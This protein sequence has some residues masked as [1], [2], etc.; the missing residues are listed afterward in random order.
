MNADYDFLIAGGGH[1]GLACGAVLARAGFSVCVVERNESIGGGCV[2][3]EVTLPGFQHDLYGSSHVWIHANPAFQ[4]LRQE[5]AQFGLDYIWEEDHITGHPDLNGPGI[6]IYRDV[7]KT[8]E[9]IAVYSREDAARYREIYDDWQLIR[10]GFIRT[11]FSP[12]NPPS[13]APAAFEGSVEGLN[14]MREFN[15]SSRAFVLEKFENDF[16]RASILGWAL[17]PQIF[18]DTECAGQSF[19]VLIPGIHTYGNAIPRGGSQMMPNAFARLIEARGGHVMTGSPIAQFIVREGECKGFRLADGSE[20]LAG[21]AVV[22]GLGPKVSFLDC[23]KSEDLP[24]DFVDACRRFSYGR[25]SIC[26]VHYALNEAP[27]WNN[28]RDMSACAF[29]RVFH[30]FSDI[31]R[32]YGEIVTGVAPTRPFLWVACWTTIDPS[33]APEGKHTLIMDTFVPSHLASGESWHDLKEEYTQTVM[34][35]IL[36]EHTQNMNDDNIL[37]AYY[38]TGVSLEAA[39]PCFVDGSTT[40]GERTLSQIGYFRPL[41]GYSQ[42][43]SPLKNL[44]MTG[45]SCHPGGGITAMGTITAR[46]ILDELDLLNGQDAFSFSEN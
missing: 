46:V 42:Y 7:D 3:R 18:P 2:T 23:C 17:A 29:Q 13:Y 28:G 26:R 37:A 41:P 14:R 19:Y 10:D 9:S 32:Q 38:D 12:P 20:M 33:R 1:N 25:V 24:P 35:P 39:N 27:V 30:S 44:Y 8:C 45:P 22:T 31:D 15:L 34:L 4:E 5:L 43:K 16:I 11:M 36:R 6:V 40:G 21:K